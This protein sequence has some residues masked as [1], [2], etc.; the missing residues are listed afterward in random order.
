M[1]TYYLCQFSLKGKVMKNASLI[2]AMVVLAVCT[3]GVLGD[4][5]GSGANQFEIHFVSIFGDAGSAEGTVIGSGRT[6]VDPGYI[7]RIGT[8]EI[9]NDQWDK[10][11]AAYGTVTGTPWTAYDSETHWTGANLPTNRVS[12]LEAAQFVN[13][14]NISSGYQAAYKFTGEQGTG[15][16]AL[17]TWSQIEAWQGSNLSIFRSFFSSVRLAVFR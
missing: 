15:D 12:W 9:T 11:K 10:F 5:F 1:P 17:S 2:L 14:L 16:Y 6:F 3:G 7:Y 8:Y 13:Y 4:T